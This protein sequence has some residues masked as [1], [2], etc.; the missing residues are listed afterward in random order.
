MTANID[1]TKILSHGKP[2]LGDYL[3]HLHTMRCT[4]D[5]KSCR[6]LYEPLSTV[7]GVYEE[8]REI[9][10]ARPTPR[11]KFV[12]ANTFIK[13]DGDVGVRVYDES[14]EGII[15]SWAERD[16]HLREEEKV[17]GDAQRRAGVR[18]SVKSF[19]QKIVHRK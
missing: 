5:V 13:A 16:I 2:A 14:N 18:A 12:Q 1:R 4:A 15:E 19:V 7:D 3:M 10:W 11:W 6:D 9:V 8:W 17:A